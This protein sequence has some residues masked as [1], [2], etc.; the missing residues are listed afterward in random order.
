MASPKTLNA[1]NLE[2]LGAPRLAE[3][4]MDLVQGSAAL[5]R[6]ARAALL[7]ASGS[8]AL[9]AEVRKRLATIKRSKSYINWKK[10]KT[11]LRDL[12]QQRDIITTRIGPADPKLA[13]D[14]LWQFIDLSSGLYERSDDSEGAFGEMFADAVQALG[15][16]AS[17]AKPAPET[18][19]GKVF[20]AVSIGN[21]YGV[22][23]A[24]IPT[25]AEALG[26]K[27]RA[28]L[29]AHLTDAQAD[30]PEDSDLR[31]GLMSLADLAGDVDGYI[32]QYPEAVRSNPRVAVDIATRLLGADRPKEALAALDTAPA[33]M[34][35]ST[36]WIDARLEA[37]DALG[38]G[39][40]A[41]KMR[42]QV[43][44][45]ALLPDYLRA[46]IRRLPDFDDVEAE[47]KALDFVAQHRDPA[48][49]LA[50]FIDWRA[51]DR[52][53]KLIMDR[54]DALDG[55]AYYRLSPAADALEASHPLAATVLRRIMIE[56]TLNGGKSSR[57][58]H[59]ARHLLEC[60]S[61]DAAIET[62]APLA[63]HEQFLTHL[64]TRHGRKYGFWEQVSV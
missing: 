28:A 12:T 41:Q 37:L 35:V 11:V 10:R 49:A 13:L 54:R 1:K 14:L 27:G 31:Y 55:N 4:V 16:L 30:D 29:K 19:A 6:E 51:L 24:L 61:A 45:T 9:A 20:H 58:K 50:F 3:L 36:D 25:M 18:L 39:E 64:R 40:E 17:A 38:R 42:W 57:Y 48:L 47:D 59:A 32:A 62:Y 52:A 22:Y 33:K 26:E 23:D 2:T 34:G 5:K 63:T 8:E 43:F 46:Y 60:E 44:E 21:G 15:P 7:E 56:D 53:A